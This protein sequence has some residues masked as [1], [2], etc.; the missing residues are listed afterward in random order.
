MAKAALSNPAP[1]ALTQSAQVKAVAEMDVDAAQNGSGNQ[2]RQLKR[3]P[4]DRI[5]LTGQRGCVRGTKHGRQ[6]AI[7]QD[8][9][10]RPPRH[11][12]DHDDREGGA[13]GLR[14]NGPSKRRDP[15]G[16]A[17]PQPVGLI[18]GARAPT[19]MSVASRTPAQPWCVVVHRRAQA[20]APPRLC[21]ARR[22]LAH[23]RPEMT[24]CAHAAS[25]GTKRTLGWAGSAWGSP[26]G[27]TGAS[28]SKTRSIT[29][30]VYPDD[31]SEA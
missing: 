15:P 9:L 3:G 30:S 17:L 10:A 25:R 20:W 14:G 12:H 22:T 29:R 16:S 18:R 13:Q 26:P 2:H 23:P 21:P 28:T 6:T 4:P 11:A 27:S 7:G 8:Q 5:R 1:R 24:Q 31:V 19:R